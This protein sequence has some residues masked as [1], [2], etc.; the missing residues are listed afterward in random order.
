MSLF[1]KI[2]KLS[3]TM[4]LAA[5]ACASQAQNYP[6]KPITLVVGY[7][8]GGATDSLARVV[9]EKLTSRLGQAVIVDNKPGANSVIASTFVRQA[10]P[11]GYTLY[12]VT[13]SFGQAPV[14]T[15]SVAKYD[16]LKDFTIVAQATGLLNVMVV[17]PNL[18]IKSVREL[19]EHAKANPG[20]INVATTGIGSTDHLGGELFAYKMGVKLNFVP[21]KG[22]APAIQ[23]VI[24][25]VADMRL[26]AMPSSRQFIET[27]K[28]RALAVM[29]PKRHAD[30]PNIAAIGETAAGLDYGGYFGVVGPRGMSPALVTRLNSEIN[31]VLKMPEVVARLNALGMDVVTGSASDFSSVIDKDR[32][33]WSKLLADTGLKIE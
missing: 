7:A 15:P 25:G 1:S 27:G 13:T 17:N 32:Q 4:V 33:L 30:F 28:L 21:Y 14:V 16:P 2:L 20:K 18:P 31:Q 24:A 3:G 23:D 11:D 8:P 9:A 5:V 19:I 29:E 26:D 6:A 12:M 10:P 22:G